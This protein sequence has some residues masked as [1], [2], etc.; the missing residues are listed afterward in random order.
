MFVVYWYYAPGRCHA[1]CFDFDP[2]SD[3]IAVF[4]GF[5]GSEGVWLVPNTEQQD[6]P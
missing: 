4:G 1:A 3:R 6:D 2:Y 5:T